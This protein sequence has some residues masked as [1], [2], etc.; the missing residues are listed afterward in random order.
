[1]LAALARLG[2][3]HEQVHVGIRGWVPIGVGAKQNDGLGTKLLRHGS[4]E[5][6]NCSA[7]HHPDQSNEPAATWR[8]STSEQT[9]G[10]CRGRPAMGWHLCINGSGSNNRACP[11]IPSE[12]SLCST[13]LTAAR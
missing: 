11:T 8:G 2:H 4:A 3:D 7:L 12:A 5:R 6:F 1:P 10:V 9:G 13:G